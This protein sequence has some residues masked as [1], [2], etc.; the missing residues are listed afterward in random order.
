MPNLDGVPAWGLFSLACLYLTLT[1]VEKILKAV[2]GESKKVPNTKLAGEQASQLRDLHGWHDQRDADG[3]PAWFV[4]TSL[5]QAVA[6]QAEILERLAQQSE[7][8]ADQG[9][10]TAKILGAILAHQKEH[11]REHAAL[12]REIRRLSSPNLTPV[13]LR[14]A[15]AEVG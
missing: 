15:K 5:K 8:Q 13:P 4:T 3:V 2:R 7:R 10:Q 12:V 1:A 6:S 14:D 9:D 11:S